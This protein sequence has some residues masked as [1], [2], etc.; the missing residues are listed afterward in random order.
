MTIYRRM[1]HRLG[2]TRWAAAFGRRVGSRLDSRL[3]AATNGRL[4]TLGRETTPVLLLTT[5]GRRTG[6][7]RTTPVIFIR[8]GKG[9][10]IS[11]ED[12]GQSRPAAWPLNLDAEPY[13]TVKVGSATMTCVARRLDDAEVDRYWDRLVE[14]WPAHATYLRRSGQRHTFMLTPV[15]EEH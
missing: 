10:V 3:Y 11:S 7:A 5:V 1:I 8:E 4:T 13:A 12:F 9:F 15:D 2:H 6:Q 14:A